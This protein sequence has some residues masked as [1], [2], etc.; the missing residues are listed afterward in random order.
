SIGQ[1]VNDPHA[2]L[3]AHAAQA[4]RQSRPRWPGPTPP[5]QPPPAGRPAGPPR[6][7]RR[8]CWLA[9]AMAFMARPTPPAQPVNPGR[10]RS[11]RRWHNQPEPGKPAPL[12]NWKGSLVVTYTIPGMKTG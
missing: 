5:G 6:R 8:G 12:V 2:H 1:G 7:V 10:L 4:S 11:E 9:R 3:T